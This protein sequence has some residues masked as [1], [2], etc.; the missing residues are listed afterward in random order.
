MNSFNE[1]KPRGIDWNVTL[2][3]M[4]ANTTTVAGLMTATP[5][6]GPMGRLNGRGVAV[7]IAVGTTLALMSKREPTNPFVCYD[8]VPDQ[9]D[10][11]LE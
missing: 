1:L 2:G 5:L 11:H 10:Y 9:D 3:N 7:S 4:I 8:K 6:F